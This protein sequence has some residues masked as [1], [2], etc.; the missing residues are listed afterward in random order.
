MTR[1]ASSSDNNNNEPSRRKILLSRNGPHFDLNRSTGRIEFGATVQ[2]VTQLDETPQPER[3]ASFLSEERSLALSIWEESKMKEI[4]DSVYQLQ[5]MNLQFVT[6]QLAP[7]VD[8]K[9]QTRYVQNNPQQ[10]VFLLQSVGFDPNVQVLGRSMDA[11]ELGIEIEVSGELRPTKDGRGV[12][13][14][15]S[16][17]SSGKLP[18]PLRL[19]PEA[20]LQAATEGI[21][22]LI[23]QFAIQSFE[24]GCRS[25]YQEFCQAATPTTTTTT[26][27]QKQTV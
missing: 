17:Q 25:K 11:H 10:P 8:M 27:E 24:T 3:I 2:L 13:G 20:A 5:T 16:F 6:I 4:R 1:F 19:L 22:R 14:K 18:P 7:T 26:I 12:S 9:M 15:I 23:V 21:N